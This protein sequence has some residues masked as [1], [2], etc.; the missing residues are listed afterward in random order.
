MGPGSFSLGNMAL[1]HA[2]LALE[3]AKLFIAE[4]LSIKDSW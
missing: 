1:Q 2:L 3:E 4:H